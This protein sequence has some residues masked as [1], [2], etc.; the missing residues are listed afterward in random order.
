M[1]YFS[2]REIVPSGHLLDSMSLH[3][4]EQYTIFSVP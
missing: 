2:F 3:E 4:E 1:I